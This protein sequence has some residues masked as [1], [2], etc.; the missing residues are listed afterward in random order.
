MAIN[1]TWRQL[2]KSRN[3]SSCNS[4]AWYVD[5]KLCP[6]CFYPTLKDACAFEI[7]EIC[8]WED[9]GQDDNDADE[10]RG[11]PNGDYS[12]TEARKNFRNSHDMYRKSD[13]DKKK[14]MAQSANIRERSIDEYNKLLTGIEP[15]EF[16]CKRFEEFYR[17][18]EISYAYSQSQEIDET[19]WIIN[20]FAHLYYC[21]FCGKYIKG[22]G[23]GD[24]R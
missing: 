13:S 7:C 17:E 14:A 23:F 6:C 4:R 24:Y 5:K 10:I 18:G 16:C 15:Q 9:D 1:S 20:G 22:R 3:A 2:Y 8:G 12:L 11:G 19:Q 21:P